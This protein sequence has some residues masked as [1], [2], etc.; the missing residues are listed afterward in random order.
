[1][2]IKKKKKIHHLGLKY[3][4]IKIPKSQNCLVDSCDLI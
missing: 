2:F 3:N 4:K 1:M